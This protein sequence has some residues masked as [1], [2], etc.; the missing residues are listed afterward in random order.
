MIKAAPK[1]PPL[2]VWGG[3][4]CTFN[5]VGDIF[6][7]QLERNGHLKRSEDLDL[8]ARLG[9]RAIRYPVSWER[10]TPVELNNADWSWADERLAHIRALG[11]R[12][13][14][15]L[16]H[17]GSGPRHTSL[18][19]S[20]FAEGL[21]SFAGA[22]A[23]RY[24]WIESYTPVNEP[25][26]TARFSGL[27]GH[28]YP[29]AHDNSTFVRALLTQ[30]RAVVLA[31]KAIRAV[32]P[33]A[34]L[35]QTDDLGKTFSTP[36]LAYQAEFENERR[37]LTFDLLC[38]KVDVHHSMWKYLLSSGASESELN[39]FLEHP[40]PPNIIGI[41]HYLTSERFLDERLER[42]P[43]LQHGGNECH[44]YAD[45]ESV[46]VHAEG[47]A[48][49]RVLLREA[50]ERYGL[51]LAVTEAHLGCTR[52]EQLRWLMETWR[53]VQELRHDSID[54]RAVTAWSL[55]GAFD[56]NKLVTVC[57]GFYE[58]GVF[59]I[60]SPK[61]RPTALA[62]LIRIL[63]S[64]HEPDHPVLAVPGWWRRPER[65]F[66]PPVHAPLSAAK[67]TAPKEER[68]M[69]I[70]PLVIT[71][72]TGTLGKAFARI[73]KMRGIPYKLLSRQEMDI[74]NIH[75]V[76]TVLQELE[77]WALVNAAGYVHVDEAEANFEECDRINAH[78]PAI[79]AAASRHLGIQLLTFS[80]DLVF[81][82]TQSHPYVESDQ[83]APLSVYGR[84]KAEG[85]ARAL[86]LCSSALVIRTSSFF[87]PWDRANFV[88][89]TLRKLLA[90][91]RVIAAHDVVMTP[92]Y[93]PDL[94]HASL[95]LLIDGE[96]G[97]WHVT[98]ATA[99]SWFD[100]ARKVAELA[101]L[102]ADTV[103]GSPIQD[104]SL[105]AP[106][107]P[108]SALSSERG[109]L[110]PSLDDALVRYLQECEVSGLSKKC[111]NGCRPL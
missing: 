69:P 12:P 61:P 105:V 20:S 15:G 32:N 84:T 35:V 79:L 2:E 43:E 22:V 6:F 78:G 19:N 73:C 38:G 76:M 60:R 46:R 11:M 25:L 101:S 28:W 67:M 24:P 80:S 51:P 87:G 23:E 14:A 48:G 3:V 68:Q 42:Y 111:E 56:W 90:K 70:R 17:H 37:W 13:I 71:G 66:Y 65:F 77:P 36:A 44:H 93:V 98:N 64:G 1:I 47:P 96:Q 89:I 58:P 21:A 92:T 102:D 8:F 31:M 57:D 34:Q 54:V 4:E 9:I 104:Q 63:A 107:P 45:V 81:D 26:T 83:P 33:S 16:V 109:Q 75:A 97:L 7:D 41:N 100:L 91:T 5:R 27:Y 29:H 74:T 72:A 85:E 50:A 110:L 99:L 106:R 10:I 86:S 62:E 55:L 103:V 82:G 18:I 49:F 95:D 40:C 39:W 59:D 108:Y 30:C 88:S 94:V 52:E 53:S